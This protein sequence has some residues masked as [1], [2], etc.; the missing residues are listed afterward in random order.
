M[1]EDDKENGFA[2]DN[3]KEVTKI[4]D[5]ANIV[6]QWFLVL[7]QVEISEM[8]FNKTYVAGFC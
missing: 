3:T 1:E 5:L 7:E 8:N 6:V 2:C 4:S